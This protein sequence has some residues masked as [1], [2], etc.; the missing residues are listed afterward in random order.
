MSTT[1]KKLTTWQRAVLFVMYQLELRYERERGH[2]EPFSLF[3]TRRSLEHAL[4]FDWQGY[5]SKAMN[6]LIELKW[7]RHEVM[8]NGV[9]GYTLT[10]A[11]IANLQQ[12]HHL[13][14]HNTWYFTDGDVPF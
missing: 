5:H 9:I 12:S 4:W 8:P 11:A 14:T 3:Q 13:M 10:P 7:I 1:R 6:E 2:I